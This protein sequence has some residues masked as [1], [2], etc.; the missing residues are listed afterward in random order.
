M[1]ALKPSASF[2]L[3]PSTKDLTAQWRPR[4]NHLYQV[5]CSAHRAGRGREEGHDHLPCSQ[6]TLKFQLLSKEQ[7][8]IHQCG[9]APRAPF[10]RTQARSGF[11]SQA[12]F[13]PS[14]DLSCISFFALLTTKLRK[15]AIDLTVTL[16]L[17]ELTSVFPFRRM[18]TEAGGTA[19]I[20]ST[21]HHG[22][23]FETH[24]CRC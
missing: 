12:A 9:K 7:N 24:I 22:A 4:L 23:A 6:S 16:N 19:A 18:T 5:C 13:V 10:S 11:A 20:F 1:A 3:P 21:S 8:T 17:Q 15:P 14:K 2:F